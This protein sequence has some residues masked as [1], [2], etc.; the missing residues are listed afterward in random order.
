MPAKDQRG[1]VTLPNER[2]CS[3]LCTYPC[4]LQAFLGGYLAQ[5]VRLFGPWGKGPKGTLRGDLAL[6]ADLKL[7]FCA[8]GFHRLT[9]N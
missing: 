6:Q 4:W 9:L 3:S 8:G 2:R 1:P 5:Q 7:A